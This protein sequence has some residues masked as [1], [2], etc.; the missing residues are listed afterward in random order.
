MA[1]AKPPTIKDRPPCD[2]PNPD[3][4]KSFWHSEPS[5]LLTAHRTTRDLPSKAD[6]VII[7]SGITGASVAHHLLNDDST[8]QLA[9]PGLQHMKDGFKVVMLEAR[10]ACWG[11][12]GRNGGH[13]QPLLF[14]NPHDPSIG[15]FELANYTTL[16]KL[17]AEKEID[18]E[19]HSQPGVRAIYS[20]SQLN[21]VELALYT[22]K[23]TSPKIAEL[24][25]LVTDKKKL[26]DLRI[27]TAIG[28]VVTSVAARLWPYKFVARILED[29]LK[30]CELKGSFNLQTTTPV[31]ALEASGDDVWDVYTPRGKITANKVVLATNA[32]TSHLLPTFSDLIV[33]VRGHM[34][35]LVPEPSVA[36]EK[37]LKTSFSMMG[38]GVDDYLIQ[39]PSQRGEHLMFGGG[40]Q[41]DSFSVGNA[42]DSSMDP[43]VMRYLRRNLFS[44]LDLQPKK[45]E[46][47]KWPEGEGSSCKTCR[48]RAVS[49]LHPQP[50]LP[51][52]TTPPSNVT[53]ELTQSHQLECDQKRP[54]CTACKHARIPCTIA[55]PPPPPPELTATH[56]WTGT[57][58]FSRDTHPFVGPLP[59]HPNLFISAGYTGHGMPNTWLCG[60][61][62]AV[63]IMNKCRTDYHYPI[64]IDEGAETSAQKR[65]KSVQRRMLWVAGKETGL[66]KCYFVTEERLR[67]ARECEAVEVADWAEMER[68]R[69][70]SRTGGRM[71][72]GY[73]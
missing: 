26:E 71:A 12:T 2:L 28:A 56:A 66:P 4:T 39:R 22:V 13:C 62:V 54:I 20:R 50:H 32:H 30:S 44:T 47:T 49:I 36:G 3:S 6:V 52:L 51:Y 33:P 65:E 5:P 42:D 25:T 18:C 72:S 59:G 35:A 34:T 17:I 68:G 14:E 40:R 67:K 1:S 63:M 45:D 37:R 69:R 46:K 60:K 43:E 11:A 61:A 73:A 53:P 23:E 21:E 64:F 31:T 9:K 57:M 38:E 24:M 19:W 8:Y 16:A 29:L 10:E 70:S 41:H 7:G 58:G 15:Q 55:L 48:A 27:P